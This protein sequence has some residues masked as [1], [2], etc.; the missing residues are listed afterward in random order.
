[1]NNTDKS[2]P[3]LPTW[4]PQGIV[5]A[6]IKRTLGKNEFLFQTGSQAGHIFFIIKGELRAIRLLP[7]G[8]NA[9]MQRASKG[10][11]FAE[12][13]MCS[14]NYKCDAIANR[15]TEVI[16]IPVDRLTHHL[17][18]DPEFSVYFM[19]LMVA[20]SLKQCKKL[21]RLRI[22]R[23][24]DRVLHYLSCESRDHAGV[25]L[26]VSVAK[27][28]EELGLEPETLYRTLSDLEKEALIIRKG[29]RIN[30]SNTDAILACN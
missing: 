30:I 4:F 1:M 19:K 15:R 29:N 18:V 5:S 8:T 17:Q 7:T 13:A 12:A 26:D 22:S 10:E 16:C 2:H 21:E 11:F 14:D 23:A 27:W 6:C 9:I 20:N 3:A 25:V 28:A 24:R